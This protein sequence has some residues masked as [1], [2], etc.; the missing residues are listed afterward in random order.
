VHGP[1]CR[2]KPAPAPYAPS[3]PFSAVFDDAFPGKTLLQV[4][5]QGEG[6][7]TALGRHTVAALVGE[8]FFRIIRDQFQRVRDGDRFWHQ[9]TLSPELLAW[10]ERQ[11]LA[12]VIRR[13]TRVG[14]E[15]AD[16]VF[17]VR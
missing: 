4:L 7:L 6:G 3:T 15:I 14:S 12:K 17:H 5:Q 1:P 11:T 8:L 13:N 16:D 10:V 9:R 2:S